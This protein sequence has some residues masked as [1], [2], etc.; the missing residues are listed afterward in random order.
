M[1]VARIFFMDVG[2][3]YGGLLICFSYREGCFFFVGLVQ[4]VSSKQLSNKIVCQKI[5]HQSKLN[6]RID[7]VNFLSA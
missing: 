2:V 5:F 1:F 6:F 4:L 3:N 7:K